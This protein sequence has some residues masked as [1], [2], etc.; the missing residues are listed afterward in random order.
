MHMNIHKV[1]ELPKVTH[2]KLNDPNFIIIFT[3]NH[4][5]IQEE[6]FFPTES[7]QEVEPSALYT[8]TSANLVLPS[9]VF[10]LC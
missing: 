6:V 2:V 9:C 8:Y 1:N 5:F 10:V 4:H 3:L 7:L